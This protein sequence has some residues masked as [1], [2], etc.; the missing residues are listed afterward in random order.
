MVWVF[1][2]CGG[3]GGRVFCGGIWIVDVGEVEEFFF[4]E[5]V[6]FGNGVW[7]FGV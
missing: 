2:Y 5:G 7:E 6:G 4:E 3:G 1:W